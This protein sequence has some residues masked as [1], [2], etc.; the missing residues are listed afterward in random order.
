MRAY[1]RAGFRLEGTRRHAL[2]QDGPYWDAHRMAILSEEF[3]R[4]VSSAFQV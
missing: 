2:F 4:Q 3:V 1:E